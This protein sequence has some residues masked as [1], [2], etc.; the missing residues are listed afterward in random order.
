M[1]SESVV[2]AAEPRLSRRRP[3]SDCFLTQLDSFVHGLNDVC[4]G[5]E[6]VRN[7]LARPYGDSE[8]GETEASFR[9]TSTFQSRV[10]VSRSVT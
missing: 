9:T 5:R 6:P 8:F 1:R 3:H 2:D 4:F 7:V 10:A